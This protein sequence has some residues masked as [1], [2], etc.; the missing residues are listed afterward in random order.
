MESPPMAHTAVST[1]NH[2]GYQYLWNGLFAALVAWQ[3]WMTLGLFGP[4]EALSR[5]ADDQPIVSGRHPLHLYHG[6]LGARS[7]LEQ[8][9]PCCY[10][11]AFQAGY[12]KTPVFDSGSRPAEL[13]LI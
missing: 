6:Y 10:D 13:F 2:P 9:T 7:I 5:L 11:P 3:S 1:P 4:S 12:P 8:G